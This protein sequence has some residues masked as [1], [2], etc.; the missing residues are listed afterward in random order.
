M[1]KLFRFRMAPRKQFA[2]F[3]VATVSLA[4]IL[5]AIHVYLFRRIENRTLFAADDTPAAPAP[6]VNEGK[7][8]TVL[9]RFADKAVMRADAVSLVPVSADPS[10]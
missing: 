6:T 1:A 2:R 7:L 4:L 3:M 5:V 8:A 10:K 9:N